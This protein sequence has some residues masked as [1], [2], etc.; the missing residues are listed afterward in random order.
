MEY[1][2]FDRKKSTTLVQHY[3]YT[4]I[5]IVNTMLLGTEIRRKYSTWRMKNIRC[6]IVSSVNHSQKCKVLFK[7]YVYVRSISREKND[8]FLVVCRFRRN[9]D[10]SRGKRFEFSQSHCNLVILYALSGF[11]SIQRWTRTS[12]WIFFKIHLTSR[13]RVVSVVHSSMRRPLFDVVS[14][15]QNW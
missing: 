10:C 15:K 6:E 2:R 1:D 14:I 5:Y 13:V 3:V 9:R 7:L 4:R 11:I 8:C 12:F